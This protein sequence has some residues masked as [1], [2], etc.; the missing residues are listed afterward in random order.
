MDLIHNKA[1]RDAIKRS[2]G[3]KD[4]AF[5][6]SMHFQDIIMN[7]P[8]WVSSDLR[9]AMD[10]LKNICSP[11]FVSPCIG[12]GGTCSEKSPNVF[13]DA[14]MAKSLHEQ[15]CKNRDN[16]QFLLTIPV[17]AVPIFVGISVD[18]DKTILDY[19]M[20]IEVAI[21]EEHDK[22]SPDYN[23]IN[24]LIDTYNTIFAQ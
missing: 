20:T 15:E 24:D 21:N 5:A 18:I 13:V 3:D 8:L 19:L 23:V 16:Y 2:S 14:E 9:L 17:G 7:R 4:Y 12:G 11:Q 22:A 10:I 1:L 6:L